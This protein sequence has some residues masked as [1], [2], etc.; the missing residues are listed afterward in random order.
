MDTRNSHA[1]AQIETSEWDKERATT[2]EMVDRY[3]N[4]FHF[5]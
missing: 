5:V 2:S 3:S 4:Y 1:A